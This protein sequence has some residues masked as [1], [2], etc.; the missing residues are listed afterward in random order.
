MTLFNRNTRRVELTEEG[1]VFLRFTRQGLDTL[2][3]ALKQSKRDTSWEAESR[4]C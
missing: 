4:C 2:L 1:H 3:R